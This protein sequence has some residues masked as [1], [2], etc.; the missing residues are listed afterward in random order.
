MPVEKFLEQPVIPAAVCL[1][2]AH[3]LQ[4]QRFVLSGRAVNLHLRFAAFRA[5]HPSRPRRAGAPPPGQPQQ[6]L[7][8]QVLDQPP[9]LQILQ[10]AVGA[11]PL[12][13]FTRRARDLGNAQAGKIRGDLTDQFEI[14]GG[15][16]TAGKG[17]CRQIRLAHRLWF[18]LPE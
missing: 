12:Q 3:H 15:K 13:K 5:R 7:P 1:P 18:G 6:A 9:A 14:G 11:F 17:Q 16:L 4:A 2:P 10:S 8:G